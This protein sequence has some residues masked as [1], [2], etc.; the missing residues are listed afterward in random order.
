[1]E[2]G[3]LFSSF[4]L[5]LF[6]LFST[7]SAFNITK[8]LEKQSDFSNFNSLLSETKLANEINK[9]KTITVLAVDN[10]GVGGLSGGSSDLTKKILSVH[11]VLDYYDTDKLKKLF[12]SNKS[13][14]LTTMFQSTGQARHQQGFIT[15]SVKD[16]HISFASAYKGNNNGGNHVNLVKSV[17]SQPYN[18][19]VLQVGSIIDV[20]DIENT[21]SSPAQSPK[22]AKAPSPS[23]SKK[24]GDDGAPSPSEDDESSS[25]KAPAPSKKK[26]DKDDKGEKSSPPKPSDDDSSSDSAPAPAP[27]SPAPSAASRTRGIVA[28]GAAVLFM[29]LAS[30]LAA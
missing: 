6:L 23:K 16:N 30:L 4:F 15:V 22:S 10:G 21:D 13:V 17:V 8:I 28:V 19:S 27:S 11:V 18:I 29:G 7:S 2:H 20:P 26:H 12:K 3:I 14:T 25:D 5:A 24:G 1:M 9:R